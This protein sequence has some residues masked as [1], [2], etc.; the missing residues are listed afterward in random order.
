[1]YVAC[2][3]LQMI[4]KPIIKGVLLNFESQGCHG[5]LT[6]LRMKRELILGELRIQV[7]G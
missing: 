2:S 6:E 7:S 1:M 5:K 4:L 3:H